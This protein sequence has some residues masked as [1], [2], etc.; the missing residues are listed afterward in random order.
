MKGKNGVSMKI[1][2]NAKDFI[3]NVRA[4]RRSK[5]VGSDTNLL[6]QRET[7]NVI[8]NY[9]KANN[10]SFQSLIKFENKKNV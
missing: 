6:S 1:D 4:T 7:L 5:I 9:F 3:D 2:L 10:D 8:V